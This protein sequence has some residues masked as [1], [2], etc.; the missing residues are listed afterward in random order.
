[1]DLFKTDFNKEAEKLKNGDKKAAERIFDHFSPKIFRFFMTRTASRQ[2]SEDLTQEVFLK[3]LEKIGTFNN[4]QGYFSSWFWQI[5]KN[6]L[7][8]HYREKKSFATADPDVIAKKSLTKSSDNPQ[9]NIADKNEIEQVLKIVKNFSEEE[10][11]IF[12]LRFLSE[13]SY[14][15]I[16]IML[17]KSEGNLR[18]ISHRITQKIQKETNEKTNENN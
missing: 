13:L 3:L 11:E 6:Q 10:Q 8:D 14:K 17:N 4:A 16:S 7:I 12:S 15:E 2:D 5:A 9:K 18:V 1:M